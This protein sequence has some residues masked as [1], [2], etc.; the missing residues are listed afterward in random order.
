MTQEKNIKVRGRSTSINLPSKFILS[1]EGM[2]Y[3]SQRNIPVRDLTTFDG[4]RK[5]GFFWPS[6]KA[7]L[8]Q[9]MVVNRLLEMIEVD[10]HEFL[11]KRE[12]IIDVTK[13]LVYGVLYK[14]FK[15]ALNEIL[16][17]SEIIEK[18][19]QANPKK[20]IGPDFKFN[21]DIVNNFMK[22]NGTAI[23]TLKEIL[24]LDPFAVIENDKDINERDKFEKKKIITRFL[25]QIDD[26]M[27][28]L[29]H[30]LNKTKSKFE[31]IEQ[32][33]RILISFFKKTKIADYIAFML[34][35][36]I[37]NAEKAHL[38][39]LAKN[40]KLMSEEDN[41]DI[42][43]KSK[44]FRE[45]LYDSAIKNR[46]FINLSYKFQ[47]DV[48]SATNR[49]KL[50]IQIINKGLLVDKD[51]KKLTE[52]IKTDT[53]EKTLA[54]FYKEGS[55]EKLGA[56][57]GLYYLSYLEDACVEENMKFD[58]RIVSDDKKEETIVMIILHI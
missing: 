46:Q 20:N 49:L 11:T 26:N 27:W 48:F 2:S 12:D 31:I 38:E 54:N 16:F 21:E 52:K 15:P 3:F 30:F 7:G 50:Q 56:G 24:L 5:S 45:K 1:D 43:L 14:K 10:R 28:F 47:G 37:Q 25:E 51:K 36:L 18:I 53:K 6:F 9:K 42:L 22:T 17:K 34:M 35:E 40:K 23:A 44:Q 33:T 58:A 32:I 41:I 55:G 4:R 29:F 13:L 57:L 39:K 19:K 8:I